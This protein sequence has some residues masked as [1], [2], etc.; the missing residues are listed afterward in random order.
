MIKIHIIRSTTRMAQRPFPPSSMKPRSASKKLTNAT[1]TTLRNACDDAG[2]L[3]FQY[4]DQR[5]GAALQKT[6]E[7]G[8]RNG[9]DQTLY[10]GDQRHGNTAGHHARV[11]RAEQRDLL[12]G[13]DHANHC[14]QKTQQRRHHINDLDQRQADS[15][16]EIS[17]MMASS[18]LSSSA[19]TS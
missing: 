12:E 11:A 15:S 14:T 2:R 16:G 1:M 8:Q 19:S 6:V 7:D 17:R 18:S 4:L 3:L 10:R 9:H 13:K 5:T